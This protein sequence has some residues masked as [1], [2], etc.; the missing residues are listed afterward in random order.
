MD[1]WDG[2][3]GDFE[4][5]LGSWR[6]TPGLSTGDMAEKTA[7]IMGILKPISGELAVQVCHQQLCHQRLILLGDIRVISCWANKIATCP[8]VK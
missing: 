3:W 2:E 4:F 1:R 5:Y 8:A 6:D 7:E